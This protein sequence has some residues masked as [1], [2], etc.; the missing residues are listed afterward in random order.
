[1]L[2]DI[3]KVPQRTLVGEVEFGILLKS[4]VA[5]DK[6]LTEADPN[7]LNSL[8]PGVVREQPLRDDTISRNVSQDRPTKEKG[9]AIGRRAYF[10]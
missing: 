1:M 3:G 8:D 9:V 5:P 4:L 2:L 7:L 6:S 10:R